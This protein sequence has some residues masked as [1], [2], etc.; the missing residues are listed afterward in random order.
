[1]NRKIITHDELRVQSAP[2]IMHFLQAGRRLI[3]M[4]DSRKLKT[5]GFPLIIRA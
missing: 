5:D 1:M 4:E 3:E 2:V